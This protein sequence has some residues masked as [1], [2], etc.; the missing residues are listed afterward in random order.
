MSLDEIPVIY[1]KTQKARELKISVRTLD[2]WIL[3][4]KIKYFSLP[5]SKRKWFLPK[6]YENY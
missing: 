1:T 2:R 4:K 6:Q 3:S 5:K